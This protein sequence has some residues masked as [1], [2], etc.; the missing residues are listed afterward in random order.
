[1]VLAASEPD[2]K[3]PGA[4]LRQRITWTPLADG[5]VRQLWVSSGDGG[6]TWTPVFD[7]KYAKARPPP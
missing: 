3:K 7:G 1:M 2:P 6:A 5:A 4:T